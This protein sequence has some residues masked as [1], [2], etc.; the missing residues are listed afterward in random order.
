MILCTLLGLNSCEDDVKSKPFGECSTNQDAMNMMIASQV[1]MNRLMETAKK[2]GKVHKDAYADY[3]KQKLKSSS[4]L[5][6]VNQLGKEM[7][8]ANKVWVDY[9]TEINTV[10]KLINAKEYQKSCDTY[11][12]IAKKYGVNLEEDAK[13]TVTMEELKKGGTCALEEATVLLMYFIEEANTKGESDNPE[14]SDLMQN[15]GLAMIQNPSKICKQIENISKKVNISYADLMQRVNKHLAKNKESLNQRKKILQE[16]AKYNKNCTVNDAIGL[17]YKETRVRDSFTELEEKWHKKYKN[18][19][20]ASLQNSKL[21]TLLLDK[22]KEVSAL[23]HLFF[24]TFKKEVK[25]HITDT[26]KYDLACKNYAKLEKEYTQ[27]LSKL[28]K[29]YDTFSITGT[30]KSKVNDINGTSQA[31]ASTNDYD[32]LANRKYNYYVHVI[33]QI[34]PKIRNTFSRYVRECG[35]DKKKRVRARVEYALKMSGGRNKK[36]YEDAYGYQLGSP[37]SKEEI[38]KTLNVFTEI[39][40]IDRFKYADAT[41]IEFKKYVSEFMKLYSEDAEYFDMK[42]YIDDAFKKGNALH[43][44]IITAFENIIKSD[45]SLRKIVNEISDKQTLH[46]IKMY[47]ENNEMLYYHVEKGQYLSKKFFEFG[48]HKK[49]YINLDAKL[50][51]K[52]H[53]ELRE[54]YE[55]FKKYRQNNEILF[56]D[57]RQYIEYLKTFKDYVSV[58]KEFYIRVKSK[59]AYNP[60]EKDFSKYIP[61]SARRTMEA[62]KDGSLLKLLNTYNSLVNDYNSLNR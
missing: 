25:T 26:G 13:T 62:N 1:H 14:V 44:P 9:V 43:A 47:K 16:N 46:R 7:G 11:I 53:D 21:N 30:S 5:K 61:A 48:E 12:S 4:V 27:K 57:N 35:S 37:Y 8:D 50:V 45:T 51:R 34:T 2:K 56:K 23:S 32:T 59:K 41:I 49:N 18:A 60:G 58:S 10:S 55:A 29:D 42:D 36:A 3:R 15:S 28:Q 40:S 19:R 31:T 17:Y 38:D 33:N 22:R 20:N 24:E 54:H 39:L 6:R 52:R